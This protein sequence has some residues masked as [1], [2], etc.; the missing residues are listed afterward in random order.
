M[1]LHPALTCFLYINLALLVLES[2]DQRQ[3]LLKMGGA[4]IHEFD[5]SQ[6]NFEELPSQRA[7]FRAKYSKVGFCKSSVS[8]LV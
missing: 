7:E 4:E 6:S 5:D 8:G 2:R 3:D 1:L